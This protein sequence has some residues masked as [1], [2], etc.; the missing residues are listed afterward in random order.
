ME[1]ADILAGGAE[2][3]RRFRLVEAQQVHHRMLD[4]VG[5]HRHRL[6]GDVAVAAVL[7]DGEMR[8]ASFW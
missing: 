5:R 3:E 8:S 6:V 1:A 4:V 7:A 2:K